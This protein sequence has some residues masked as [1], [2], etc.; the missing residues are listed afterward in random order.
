MSGQSLG[1]IAE[2]LKVAANTVST[3]KTRVMEKLGQGSL[4]GLFR[5]AIRKSLVN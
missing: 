1:D 3:Y 2:D 5:F 4:S